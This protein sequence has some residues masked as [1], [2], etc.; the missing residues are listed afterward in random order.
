MCG[1]ARCA[2]GAGWQLLQVTAVMKVLLLS[3]PH[4]QQQQMPDWYCIV[5]RAMQ[6]LHR[7]RS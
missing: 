6:K 4:Q 3:Q 1:T 7:S 5:L 2:V